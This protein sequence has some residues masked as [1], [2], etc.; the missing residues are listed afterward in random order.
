[1]QCTPGNQSHAGRC[2]GHRERPR[3]AL[4]STGL[5]SHRPGAP[6]VHEGLPRK[7]EALALLVPPSC[8]SPLI[9]G[10]D[11]GEQRGQRPALLCAWST[12]RWTHYEVSWGCSEGTRTGTERPPLALSHGGELLDG[13]CCGGG[14]LTDPWHTQGQ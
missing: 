5:S 2:L 11:I 13:R 9:R 14:A 1:M 7:F 12:L 8:L 10:L 6:D 3:V 4:W